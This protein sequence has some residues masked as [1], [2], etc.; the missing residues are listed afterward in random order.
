MTV[1]AWDGKTLAA[2]RLGDACGLRRTSTKIFRIG[3]SL[4]G[5][6]GYA[7]R[8]AEM[9]AWIQ[10]GGKPDDIPQFQLTDDYQDVL[11]VNPDGRVFIFGKSPTPF[12]MLDKFHAIG[13]G[14]D[15]AIAAMHLGKSAQEAVEIACLF[16]TGCGNGI[17]TLEILRTE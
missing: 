7:S 4:F 11:I 15:F 5:A 13:S 10:R 6:A 14:R 2:D 3:D 8:A 17:D 16:D 1:I 9:L 12:E